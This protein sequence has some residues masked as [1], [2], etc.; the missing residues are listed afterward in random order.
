MKPFE[1]T[2]TAWLDGELPPEQARAFEASLDPR[3]RAEA[4]AE[5]AASR[6]LGDLLRHHLPTPP[7]PNPDFFN[8]SLLERIA[9]EERAAVSRAPGKTATAAR[10]GSLLRLFLATFSGAA[11]AALTLAAVVVSTTAPDMTA[12]MTADFYAVTPPAGDYYA[13]IL[14]TE[15]G[16]PTISAYAFQAAGQPLTVLWLDGLD[17][18]PAEP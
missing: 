11:V 4:E 3:Q 13:E 18:L 12:K 16:G 7:L 6:A 9:A 10:P 14:E 15:P 17:Y 1:Q 5:W 2:Y 8:H